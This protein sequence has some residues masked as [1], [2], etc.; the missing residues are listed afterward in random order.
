MSSS[1]GRRLRT[2]VFGQSHA[3]AIGVVLDGLPAGEAIDLD[4]LTAF[5][6]RRAPGRSAVSTQRRETDAFE[7]LSG[8]V[9][10]QT[11]GAPLALV[12][13]NHDARSAS[14]AETNYVPRPSH[15]DYPATVKYGSAYDARGGGQF[16]GRLT[17]PL[18][19][20]GGV[21]KQLLRRRG[22]RVAARAQS[23]AGVVDEWAAG[24]GAF[25]EKA[26]TAGGVAVD[27][28]GSLI[29][30]PGA[31]DAAATIDALEAAT[32]RELPTLNAAAGEAMKQAILAAQA[33]GDSV[34]GVVEC[35]ATG[36]PV[37]LG[38]PLFGGIENRLAAAIFA[39]P[40]VRGIEFGAGFA[41]AN[42]RGSEHNDAY[43]VDASGQVSTQTNNHGGILGGL[44]SGLPIVFRVAFKPTPSIALPQQSVDLRSLEPTTLE[45]KGRHDPCI[46]P[47]AV[48]C[49]E[50]AAAIVLLELLLEADGGQ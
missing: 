9:D 16:S 44:S 24:A 4:E 34:G 15:A 35:L 18:C 32:G 2:T 45:I 28:A 19:L 23:I 26:E 30:V 8:L 1:F 33:E 12:I 29:A 11:C 20:A 22:V 25:G 49:V 27:A 10:G 13:Q 14:Y 38:E 50:A 39:I 21:C 31:A 3:A 36:L 48:P 46:V 43:I 42:M 5:M 6:Q 7:V 47:R 17:A 41:A 40:A 37:G